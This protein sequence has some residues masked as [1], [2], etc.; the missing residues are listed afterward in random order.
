M[1]KNIVLGAAAL[2]TL[3]FVPSGSANPARELLLDQYEALLC[4][5][6]PLTHELTHTIESIP[7]PSDP[8]LTLTMHAVCLGD[9]LPVDTDCTATSHSLTGW[10]WNTAYNGVVD[11]RNPYGLTS[12]NV[13]NAFNAGGNE[14]KPQGAPMGTLSSGGSASKIRMQDFVNQHGFKKG[15][16]YVAVT[17]TWSYSDGRAAESDAAYNTAYPWSTSGASNAMDLQNVAT[18]ELGHT[19]GMGHSANVSSNSCLTMY[20]Y[21]DYGWTHQRTLGDGDILGINKIY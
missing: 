8:L 6:D 17:Y 14:W 2:L 21:V 10:Y 11:T 12:S 3:A 9:L 20:P 5:E 16:N 4:Q 15:G 18:H 7:E 13:L 19:F 1:N